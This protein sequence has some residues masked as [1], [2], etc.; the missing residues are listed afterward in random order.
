MAIDIDNS[1]NIL[2][3]LSEHNVIQVFYLGRSGTELHRVAVRNDVANEARRQSNMQLDLCAQPFPMAR[4]FLTICFS[5]TFRIVSI[6]AVTMAESAQVHLVAVT[7]NGARLYFTTRRSPRLFGG[8]GG[9]NLGS[10]ASPSSPASQQRPNAGPSEPEALELMHV[11]WAP[12]LSSAQNASNGL[13]R[14]IPSRVHTAFYS[15]G[16]LILANAVSDETDLLIGVS[17]DLGDFV[18]VCANESPRSHH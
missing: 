11:R 5:A 6:H 9:F 4:V 16:T 13:D 10:H 15:A 18:K 14:Q 8:P 17:Q 7:S 1:R 12:S 3:T 2:Y